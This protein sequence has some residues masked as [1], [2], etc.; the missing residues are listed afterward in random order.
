MT[1]SAA[2]A[3][4]TAPNPA[5]W[6]TVARQEIG[7][8]WLS[9]KGLAVLFAFSLLLALLS[10][11]ASAD[12]GIN[13]L[14][15]RESVGVIVQT[16]IA[17]GTLAALVVSADAI[18]G[19]RERGTLEALLVQSL[20]LTLTALAPLAGRPVFGKCRCNQEVVRSSCPPRSPARVTP[21]D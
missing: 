4:R 13:L 14:D 5:G 16:S 19:E 15:A 20:F 18:S 2:T 10:Y 3:R 11:I 6:S 9:S 1:T 8:L 7:E 17:L 21:C 12:A